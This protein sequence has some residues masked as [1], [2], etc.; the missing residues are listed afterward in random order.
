MFPPFVRVGSGEG[1]RSLSYVPQSPGKH[2]WCFHTRQNVFRA[3]VLRPISA[4]V[5]LQP[6]YILKRFQKPVLVT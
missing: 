5:A 6:A 4:I 1:P 3:S 2:L